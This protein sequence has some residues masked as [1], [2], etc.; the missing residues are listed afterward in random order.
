MD[1]VLVFGDQLNRRIGALGSHAPGECRVL[2]VESEA[3]L[4]P[5][6]HVQRLHLVITAM[7]RFAGELRDAGFEVDLRRSATMAAGIEDHV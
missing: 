5:T 1:T 4:R 7:R 2:L 6:R 3:L